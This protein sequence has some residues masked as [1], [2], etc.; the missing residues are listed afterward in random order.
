[1]AN[2]ERPSHAN[3]TIS[4]F[5]LK[6]SRHW[7]RI[8]LMIVGLYATLPFAAPTLM[9]LGLTAPANLIYTIYSPMCH[10]FAFRSFFLYGEQTFYP[11]Q[12]AGTDLRPYEAYAAETPGIYPGS[13]PEDFSPSFWLPARQFVGNEQMGYKTTLCARDASIYLT[14]FAA[15]LIYAIPAV[16]RKIRPVPIWLYVIVGLGPIGLDGFSQLLSYPP[17]MLWSVRETTPFFRVAT[18]AMFGLMNA[19]LAF[20]YLELSFY[21]TRR[22]LEYKLRQATSPQQKQ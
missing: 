1:M 19:W 22:Q 9:K 17:F 18:G 21:D 2:N 6:M 20:P 10:Q 11:R 14:M 4:R 7:L 13:S 12:I 3:L 8:A 15:G 16:R 5:M